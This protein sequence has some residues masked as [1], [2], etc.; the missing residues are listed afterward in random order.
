[1]ATLLYRLGRFSFRRRRLTL[2]VWV[3]V[4]ALLGVGAAMLSGPTT[5]EFSIPGSESSRA[6]QV[7]EEKFGGGSGG[8][9]AKVVFTGATPLTAD[10]LAGAVARLRQAPQVAAVADPV[11]SA[12]QRTAYTTVTYSG[13]VAEVTAEAKDALLAVRAGDGVGVEF[14]GEVTVNAEE[15]HAAEA[16]GIGVAALVLVITFGSLIAA[17]L[18]LLTALIGVGAGMLAIQIATG[19]FDLSSSTSALATML[20]LAVGIDY[21]LFV[22]SRYRHERAH[23][24][25]AE[26]AA[27][28]AVGTA[29]SAVVFAG[30]TVIIALA[31][32]SVTGIPFLTAM[33]LAA[34]GTVAVA[35]LVTLT[36]VPAI[37]GFAGRRVLPRKA[38]SV[39][40]PFGERWA[41][42]VLR[43]RW[44]ALIAALGVIAAVA[45]PAVDLRLA[46]PD[47]STAA[48]DSTQRKAY[49]Q[50]AAGFGPGFNG[51]LILVA[52]AG[53]AAT[54]EKAVSALNDVVLVTPAV[55]DPAGATAMLTVVP[56]S[57]PTSE[58]T[59]RLVH[60]IRD[61]GIA[62]LAVTGATAINIDVSEKLSGALIPYLAIVVG[63]AFVLLMLVFRSVLVPIKATT[64]FLLS[65][66][67]AFGALVAV[68]QNGHLAGLIG[69]DSTGPIV[70]IM[71]IF[72][73]GILFGLAM[74]YEVFLVTRT[75]EE[76]VHGAAPDDAIVT[77]MRH[78]ARVVT[79]A[80]LIMMS[81]FAGFILADDTIIKSLGFALAFGVAID[82]FLV[83]MTIVP[84]VLSLLGR[85]AWWLPRWLDRVL[86]DVD[87]EGTSLSVP[88]RHRPPEPAQ[89]LAAA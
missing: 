51:P 39:G 82:A 44:I 6:L 30:L 10:S 23:T 48:V 41:R 67:A 78:G 68:F 55:V 81:V 52:D 62:S 79:A 86:P 32:L 2:A 34:A 1:M 25:D 24:E 9:E 27:G 22:I 15:N 87:V 19:F 46:L 53:V 31:A 35:V 76:F 7:L 42:G 56:A 63:L 66:A 45:I 17:G 5:G 49:D 4:L 85:S 36:F 77:G 65:V 83:R 28:R 71:P 50:L 20:G 88:D 70:S 75:R 16:I 12:D 64:G 84:A 40:T 74:D 60:D 57:A 13:T 69:L 18:P 38:P 89:E 54:V 3:T 21:A 37:L 26:E 14:S 8:A 29:G 73:I 59:K 47:E 33:G 72:L 11:F 61:L 80:A 58:A 43:H